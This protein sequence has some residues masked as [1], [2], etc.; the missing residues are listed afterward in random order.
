MSI[1]S[2][3][4]GLLKGS[5][6]SEQRIE[7]NRRGAMYTQRDLPECTQLCA[8]G[9]VWTVG[10]LSA[11]A[12][13]TALPTTTSGIGLYNNEPE[14]GLSYIMLAAFATFDAAGAA[15][16]SLHLAQC[17]ATLKPTTRPTADIAAASIK[18]FGKTPSNAYGGNAIV[19]LALAVADDLWKN[20]GDSTD[21]I[22]VSLPGNCLWV[23][24]NGMIVLGPGGTYAL[25]TIASATTSNSR[26]GFVWAEVQL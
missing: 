23:P 12:S 17:V 4:Y 18:N 11:T 10:E 20:I 24:L 13:V 2:A 16:A 5:S 3:L 22:V 1:A 9:K 19:D 15:L 6:S 8:E 7:V 25:E 14:G 21:S 26:I